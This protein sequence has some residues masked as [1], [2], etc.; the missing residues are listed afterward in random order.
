MII[1]D[2][3]LS[4]SPPSSLACWTVLSALQARIV[5][6]GIPFRPSASHCSVGSLNEATSCLLAGMLVTELG[7]GNHTAK[8]RP[9][10]SGCV[11]KV[12]LWEWR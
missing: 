6:D 9:R 8:V 3:W 2:D 1:A 12:R 11:H 10:G 5:V 4:L 7:A